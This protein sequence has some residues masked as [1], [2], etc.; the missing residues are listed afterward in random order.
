MNYAMPSREDW[1]A[2]LAALR[3]V[4]VYEGLGSGES[5]P[6]GRLV[7]CTYCKTSI[8]DSPLH[9]AKCITRLFFTPRE[10]ATIRRETLSEM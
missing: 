8:S 1:E 7:H 4:A 2:A 6:D 9:T 3:E 5:R 10:L